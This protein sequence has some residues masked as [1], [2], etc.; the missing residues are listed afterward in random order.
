MLNILARFMKEKSEASA[1]HSAR[2]V[3]F[4]LNDDDD[5]GDNG[6]THMGQS[7]SAIDD[8]TASGLQ[9]VNVWD[10]EDPDAGK[11]IA[12]FIIC[13]ELIS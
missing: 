6:L 11:G 5:Q 2:N 7:L 3:N 4:N 8:F 9:A 12:F 1:A 10:D 13:E